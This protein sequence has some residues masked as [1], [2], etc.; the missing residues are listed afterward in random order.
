MSFKG[1]HHCKGLKESVF[2][3]IFLGERKGDREII[4][5]VI[6]EY[7]FMYITKN[8]YR[9]ILQNGDTAAIPPRHVEF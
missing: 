9:K 6:I 7:I 2:L 5:G 4:L 8:F 3:T 1:Q